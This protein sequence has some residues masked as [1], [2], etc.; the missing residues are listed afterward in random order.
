MARIRSKTRSALHHSFSECTKEWRQH[1][2]VLRTYLFEHGVAH[3]LMVEEADE[4]RDLLTDFAYGMSRLET[5]GMPT[6][7]GYICDLGAVRIELTDEGELEIWRAFLSAKQHFFQLESSDWGADRILFQL[8]VEHADDSPISQKAERY[9]KTEPPDWLWMRRMRR[10]QKMG[11]GPC[12]NTLIHHEDEL[13]EI[14]VWNEL[15][16]SLDSGCTLLVWN[17]A[18]NEP[19][20]E[21]EADGF[22]PHE[23]R[24]L[25]WSDGDLSIWELE[26]EDIEPQYSFE[27]ESITQALWLSSTELLVNTDYGSIFLF[28]MNEKTLKPLVEREDASMLQS[29]CLNEQQVVFYQYAW[30][31]EYEDDSECDSEEENSEEY[32]D[33]DSEEDSEYDTEEESEEPLDSSVYLLS[34]NSGSEQLECIEL[35]EAKNSIVCMQKTSQEH[36]I[37]VDSSG[38]MTYIDVSARTVDH[39]WSL[40]EAMRSEVFVLSE[41]Q[42]CLTQWSSDEDF[43]LFLVQLKAPYGV[44]ELEGH[45]DLIES[46]RSVGRKRAVSCSFDGTMRLWNLEDGACLAVFKTESPHG[47]LGVLPLDD[48]RFAAW[49]FESHVT[50][51]DIDRAQ[52]IGKLFGHRTSIAN[53]IAFPDGRLASM[54]LFDSSIRI[55][56][57]EHAELEPAIDNHSDVVLRD[58][59]VRNKV[60]LTGAHDKTL[61]L[62]NLESAQCVRQ[63][64]GHEEPLECLNWISDTELVSGGWDGLLLRWNTEG[65]VLARYE[66]HTDWVRGFSVLSSKKMLSWSEDGSLRL[67]KLKTGVQLAVLKGH[68]GAV[69]GGLRIDKN[70]WLSWSEDS[71]MRLWDLKKQKCLQ[72]FKGHDSMVDWVKVIDDKTLLSSDWDEPENPPILKIWKLKKGTCTH[73]FT[74][75]EARIDTAVLVEQRLW[76]R[77]HYGILVWDLEHPNTPQQLSEEQLREQHPEIWLKLNS[78]QAENLTFKQGRVAQATN[79]IWIEGLHRRSAHW[80]CEG[81]WSA[82]ALLD[83]GLILATCWTDVAFLQCYKGSEPAIRADIEESIQSVS[84]DI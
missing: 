58:L 71:K 52:C 81:E 63:L 17:K 12:L 46:V 47:Y 1:P 25:F 64:V 83:S 67:W 29:L 76:A 7:K 56:N 43:A 32:D 45:S 49:S 9:L 50:I 54:G 51:W 72:V 5:N 14:Q 21:L 31:E 70:S 68:K 84:V 26:D 41:D 40:F 53:V 59:E 23:D 37:V 42:I 62:W 34:R 44:I 16:V 19:L 82:R 79:S 11:A 6:V 39:R 65:E 20:V 80:F 24:L 38:E 61:R 77:L 36:L 28:D 3:L 18:F 60:L 8:A 10:P 35:F 48:F 13:S 73:S 66:G 4:A 30:C 22:V 75:A 78:E 33:E 69:R 15:L 27:E 55:W 2:I 74:G 57:P